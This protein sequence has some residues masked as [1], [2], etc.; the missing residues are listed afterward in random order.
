MPLDS[1]GLIKTSLI[2]YPGE[3]ASVLFTSGCNLR[4]PFCHNPEL[5]QHI[6]P[7]SFI[8][9]SEVLA[10]LARRQSVLGGVVVTGGE[11]CRHQDL[12]DLIDQISSLGLKIKVDTNGTYP[13]TLM[14]LSVSYLAL[15]IK[16]SPDKYWMVSAEG[17]DT[18]YELFTRETG[19]SMWDR[20]SR[21]V[22]WV[23]GSDIDHEFRTTVVPG[24]VTED[25]VKSI[26]DRIQGA[27]RY[28]L[29]GFRSI[30]TLDRALIGKAPY[31]DRVM[32]SMKSSV[33]ER[34][35]PCSIRWNREGQSG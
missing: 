1:L 15:D 24:L 32:E 12:P 31:P 26:A 25:D 4:C 11:P 20:I 22:D 28:V 10:F 3:V 6:V 33:E 23:I 16:T 8:P 29:A 17:G 19:E 30:N 21:S 34:G 27:R 7:D 2:D 13:D 5:V 9:T 14:K 35:I 18:Q